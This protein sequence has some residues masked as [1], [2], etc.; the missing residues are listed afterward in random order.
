MALKVGPGST[1]ER[2]VIHRGTAF[3]PPALL[4]LD[5]DGNALDLGDATPRLLIAETVYREP[6]FEAMVG[7]GIEIADAPNGELQIDLS[8]LQTAS[9]PVGPFAWELLVQDADDATILQIKGAGEV[10]RTLKD[11][12]AEGVIAAGPDGFAGLVGDRP[13]VSGAVS[14]TEAIL[15]R[16]PARTPAADVVGLR[17]LKVLLDAKADGA[18]VTEA[19]AAKQD[20]TLAAGSRGPGSVARSVAAKLGETVSVK[21]FGATGDGTTDITEYLDSAWN[22]SITQAFAADGQRRAL[23]SFEVFLPPGNYVYSGS[24]LSM[25][26]GASFTLRGV[27][28]RTCITIDSDIYLINISG[29]YLYGRLIGIDFVGGKGVWRVTRTTNIG[30]SIRNAR[31]IQDCSFCDYTEAAIVSNNG[32]DPFYKITACRF[33]G[34]SGTKAIVL[35]PGGGHDVIGNWFNRGKYFIHIRDGQDTRIKNNRFGGLEQADCWN[36]WIDRSGKT[37]AGNGLIITENYH[38]VENDSTTNS[39]ILVADANTSGNADH[40]TAPTWESYAHS[41]TLN[42]SGIVR[43]VTIR[44]ETFSFPSGRTA[45]V[46]LSYF[47]RL[48]AWVYE[49]NHHWGTTPYL[50][51]FRS[52]AS[53]LSA[54][55]AGNTYVNTNVIRYD[56]DHNIGVAATTPRKV[57]N[58]PGFGQVYDPAGIMSFRDG[59][60][61]EG[62]GGGSTVID[63]SPASPAAIS[64]TTT[65]ASAS[66]NG[67]GVLENRQITVNS[68]DGRCQTTLTMTNAVAGRLT[69]VEFEAKQG[70]SNPIAA[71]EIRVGAS[72][73]SYFFARLVELQATRRLYRFSFVLPSTAS[74]T[75]IFVG[76]SA[77][78]SASTNVFDLSR[79][80]AYQSPCPVIHSLPQAIPYL[81][82]TPQTA[83]PTSPPTDSVW[84]A[85]RAT[86]DPLSVGSGAAYLTRWDGSAWQNVT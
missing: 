74:A 7:T 8:E 82:V 57:S 60:H 55:A 18:D 12:L 50:F 49:S 24:G 14:E 26:G 34:A 70:G 80:R 33:T 28:G 31:I 73:S 68:A 58:V 86:W 2:W 65:V 25:T 19:L 32:D 69:W 1:G 79:V 48:A 17:P 71:I 64:S 22:E 83:A 44:G 30:G 40:S 85:D 11:N 13:A 66:A 51:E 63:L 77:Y 46:V 23:G 47:E 15:T 56:Q 5:Q 36:I 37:N 43:G 62:S 35:P 78:Y 76:P 41:T 27:P 29:A 20:A 61:L 39:P 54:F 42:T 72:F 16:D 9:L 52:G 59:V 84:M 53:A 6:T 4:V 67:F 21:D 38:G 75:I 45:G 81:N 10:L 3:R